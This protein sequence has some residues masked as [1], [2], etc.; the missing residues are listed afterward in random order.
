VYEESIPGQTDR[1]YSFVLVLY[2]EMEDLD[3]G[4][5]EKQGGGPNV[6]DAGAHQEL[7]APAVS[8]V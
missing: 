7:Q 3:E 2:P 8:S 6:A 4:A 1:Y 5:G